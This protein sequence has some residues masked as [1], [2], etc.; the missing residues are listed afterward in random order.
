M[1]RRVG[2]SKGSVTRFGARRQQPGQNTN[3]RFGG[4][5]GDVRYDFVI[6][7]DKLVANNWVG[8]ADPAQPAW[9]YVGE[10]S[11]LDRY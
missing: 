2:F 8:E 11:C 1:V 10:N 9:L 6:R 7:F 5:F 3:I 4:R